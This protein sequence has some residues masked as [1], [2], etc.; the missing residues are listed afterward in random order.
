MNCPNCGVA[1][2]LTNAKDLTGKRCPSCG[3]SLVRR[4]QET[5]SGNR[6]EPRCGYCGSLVDPETSEICSVCGYCH[7]YK[8]N[9]AESI[10]DT[11]S[12]L[13]SDE[14]QT[15]SG[16]LQRKQQPN[17]GIPPLLG[18]VCF[19]L[20]FLGLLIW[21]DTKTRKPRYARTALLLSICP[22]TMILAGIF[23]M[24]TNA[25]RYQ[26]ESTQSTTTTSESSYESVSES[27]VFSNLDSQFT[28][29][30]DSPIDN[31]RIHCSH[32]NVVWVETRGDEDDLRYVG[33]NCET[34]TMQDAESAFNVMAT[35]MGNV[36]PSLENPLSWVADKVDLSID[37]GQPVSST[38]SGILV[39]IEVTELSGSKAATDLR[40]YLQ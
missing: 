17:E 6:A 22:T 31:S 36:F 37:S 23:V 10:D 32:D 27:Q 15:G 19:L 7:S 9:I 21:A 5:P 20:P 18:L 33:V 4:P 25:P 3:K 38:I 8:V 40:I 12:A 13:P 14:L 35:I 16:E 29:E 28:L 34:V 24:T 11:P 2:V 26:Y 39:T 1:L 30:C